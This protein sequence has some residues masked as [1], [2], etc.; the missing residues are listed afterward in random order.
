MSKHVFRKPSKL[1]DLKKKKFKMLIDGIGQLYIFYC[2][3]QL[4]FKHRK[5]F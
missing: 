1:A 3:I 4:L 5:K 2:N